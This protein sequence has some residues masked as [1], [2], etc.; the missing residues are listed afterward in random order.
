[1]RFGKLLLALTL[2]LF[3]GYVIPAHGQSDRGTI[4]GTL[5]DQTGS[6][7]SGAT[8]AVTSTETNESRTV[9]T[10]ESGIFVF[11]ELKA[12]LYQ[13]TAEAT[14]FKRVSVDNVKVDVQGTRSLEIKLEVGEVTGN[15][16]TVNAEAVTLNADTPVRQTT[17]TERQV[18]ELPLQVSA[19][20]G[21]RTPL[22]F[23]F[24]DSNVGASDQ[25][26]TTNA[27]KFKVSGGQGSGV[28]I[29]IDGASTRRTQNGNFFTEVAPG[30]NAY[31]EFTIS[32]NSYSAEFGNSSG[33]IVNFTLKSG[34]NAFHG[35]AYDLLRNEVLNANSLYNI[36][37]GLERNRDNQN[38]FGF[39]VGGP[40]WVP[41]FGEGGP[42]IRKFKDRAFFFFNYEGY[43]LKQG[44]NTVTTVPTVRMRSG[45]FSE[46]LTD[47]YV[48][49]RFPNGIQ[50]YDPRQ[51]S[52][53]RAAIP[54]NRLDLVNSIING[55]PLIDPAGFAILQYFPLPTSAG[56]HNNYTVSNAIPNNANQFTIK[57][58]FNLTGKQHL[59]F[60]YS[61]RRNTRVAGPAPI[62]PL[63]Y[64]QAFGPWNQ[65]F[66]S[67]FGRL[68]HDYT[69]SSN[70]INHLN[71]GYTY[72]DVSNLNSTYGFDTSSL[73]IPRNATS[74][75]AFPL[76]DFVGDAND[77]NSA[78]FTIDI[79]GV[80]FTDRV[81]DAALEFGDSL[82]YIRGRQTFKVGATVRL[83]QY[84]VRQLVHPGGRFG[85][86]SD[87][88]AADRDP[89]GGS[90]V[91][92]LITGATEWSFVGNDSIDPAF[93]QMTQNYFIQDDIKLTSKLTVNVGLRY[94]L[95]G[96]RVE[97]KDRYRSFDPT[98]TNPIINRLGAIAGAAGQ[99][100]VQAQYRSLSPTDKT[101]WGPRVGAAYAYNS[102]TVIRAGAGLYYAPIL[103]GVGG[104]GTLKDGTIGYNNDDIL[105][106][107]NGRNVNNFLSSFPSL[108]ITG[109]VD[110][111][112]QY[113]GNTG[114]TLPYFDPNFK[115]GRTLQYTVDV[116]RELPYRLIASVGYIGHRDW[117]LRSNFG[118]LNAVPLNALKLGFTLL[119][120]NLNDVTAAER[121]Y[122]A[123]VGSPLPAS[124]NAVYN[125]F[126]GTVAQALK[127]FPQ[128]GSNINNFLESQ[129]TASY[130]ALQAKL[131]RRFAQGFQFG[132]SY[133]FSRLIT[134][135][136]DDIL[137][138]SPLGGVLQNPYDRRSL[139]TVSPT[140]SPHVF[141]ANFLAEVPFGRGKRFLDR[142]G[143]VNA[144]LG[145]FQ[146][147]GVFRY[148]AG[149]PLVPSLSSDTG[150]GSWLDL[151]GFLGNLRPNLTGQPL[152]LSNSTQVAVGQFTNVNSAAFSAPPDFVLR[153]ANGSLVQVTDAQYA[154]YYS[155][156]NRFFGT[157]PPTIT[158]FRSDPF[159][160]ENL[161]ILK[162]TRISESVYFEV[163]AEFFNLFNRV[164]FL[165]PDAYLG[166]FINGR[167]DNGN[168]GVIGAVDDPR[169]IQLRARIVF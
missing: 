141:V 23:I 97:A 166:R 91:A 58:D 14:G 59:T 118:R 143:V 93:R 41:G 44:V 131:D 133:T 153:N 62:L 76:I 87:L 30:P 138:G 164:R 89:S 25:S 104:G 113:I 134:D 84:N 18:K 70:I 147:S 12:G 111:N 32:T 120:K 119:S 161:S 78:R 79:G 116:Q 56:V 2:T 169:R 51:P 158:G 95:P 121:A 81:R 83:S 64:T 55:R 128:Y 8:V 102:K 15:V 94:D 39:N 34:T 17:V 7:V 99:G 10:D 154:A 96:Q 107:P 145:G 3:V 82:T 63:P 156:P 159:F 124:S 117:H 90:Q 168:F 85:F 130:N 47:P 52:S 151:V 72:Y 16:V 50:I 127:P 29:L 73:G 1:M 74:N 38:N 103:Y 149:L 80:D 123:S 88:T 6:T 53:T 36:G 150:N 69:I 109:P 110:P 92:S 140:N 122:A 5:V 28:E 43:R 24:L 40:I 125:G 146:V 108:S 77:P 126:N 26:G 22:A 101:N 105:L 152:V 155:D 13:V 165:Q 4:R 57:T 11:P 42:S 60:S 45:D 71:I 144:L 142:G 27:S 54:G 75:A 49:A 98:V 167:F 148:Q 65:N 135:A 61:D 162:K 137:G 136:A 115:N 19:E 86:I 20:S 31:Q 66:N 106:T 68:Q 139:K 100:G 157:A 112:S 46:L 163:G 114:L 37:R 35:E 67:K 9:T 160:S 48:L 33:G 21:G 132:L 129:G